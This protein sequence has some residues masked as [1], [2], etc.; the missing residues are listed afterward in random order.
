MIRIVS[1]A[2]LLAAALAAQ[3]PVKTARQLSA[4]LADLNN[5][6]AIASERYTQTHPDIVT[7]KDKIALVRKDLEQ[8]LDA[9]LSGLNDQYAALRLR[10]KE[11]HSRVRSVGSRDYVAR[12]RAAT[13]AS[14]AQSKIVALFSKGDGLTNGKK[15]LNTS[16]LQLR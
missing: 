10:Y 13:P 15:N 4:E 14:R 9:E 8:R 16:L 7:V 6:Y 3:P 2:I 12:A 11:S 5:R 1:L